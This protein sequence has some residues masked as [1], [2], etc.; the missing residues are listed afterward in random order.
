MAAAAQARLAT[1][2]A[3]GS[4]ARRYAQR[5]LASLRTR[6]LRPIEA[7]D[8]DPAVA[9]AAS[10]LMQL[11]G[12]PDGPP[13]PCPVPLASCA[14]GALA[15]LA[16]LAPPGAFTGIHGSRLLAERAAITGATRR[17]AISAGG[18]CRLL[19]AAD[20]WIA[21]NLA[22]DD[23]A[24]LLP[25]WLEEAIAGDWG[26]IAAAVRTRRAQELVERGRLTGL[27][28]ALDAVPSTVADGWFAA[29]AGHARDTARR[30]RPVVI[31]LSSLW[32]GPLCGHLLHLAG[33]DVIKVESTARPDGARQ[34]PPAFFDLL[35]AGKS[36]VALDLGSGTGRE[37]LRALLR[38]A[39]IVIESSRPRALRQMGIDAAGIVEAGATWISITAHGRDAER[40]GWIGY[41]DDAG[42][43]AGLSRLMH[44]A[45]GERVFAGDAIADPL[46]GLH[47]ALAA[48]A[49]YR[50][51]GGRLISLALTGALRH[52]I[53]WGQVAI[54]PDTRPG[55]SP[56]AARPR[57]RTPSGV[58]RPLGAD[59]IAVRARLGIG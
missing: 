21:L 44:E 52:C 14:D 3:A 39:D 4:V 41:G 9:W 33:A 32:A 34:G 47:A 42:V 11:T 8:A 59:T 26:S 57:A 36:S 10:G 51:G 20:G 18:S 43:A 35:N 16:S 56:A 15:A 7:N 23:D 55:P 50:A 13:L 17:G 5:L 22:R 38:R 37:H 25:A 28:V 27:A 31:D 12:R 19:Q 46:T 45:T 40:E 29:G 24:S 1:G 48:W 6:P 49:T 54:S 30:A 53:D 58:A 2:V